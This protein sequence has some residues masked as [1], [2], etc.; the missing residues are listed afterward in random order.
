MRWTSTRT[1]K[2]DV[3]FLEAVLA[4]LPADGGLY[5]PA[6]LAPLDDVDALLAL[7][8]HA[9]S[10]A[11][12]G[13]LLAPEVDE[14]TLTALV[15][16]VFRF[17]APLVPIAPG[18]AALELFHGP[19]LSFK[20]FGAR[21]LAHVLGLAAARH[22]PGKDRLVLTATSG[23]TGSAVAHAFWQRPGFRVAVLYPR[24]RISPL[25]ERQ[26]ATLGGN[27]RAFAV[28]G[29]FDDCQALVKA[30]FADP[31]LSAQLGL[32]SANSINVARL[33]AQVLYYFEAVAQH[34]AR[35]GAASRPW[36]AVPSG[37]FGNLCAGLLAERLGL[38]VGGFV[39]ATNANRAVPDYLESG[40]Y[41]PRPSLATLSN[42]MDVGAPN[43]W[44]RIAWLFGN[45]WQRLRTAL[46]WGSR[47]DA[48]TLAE[49]ER[50]AALGYAADPHGAVASAV[51]RGSL[52]PEDEG[53]FL[54][55]AHPAKFEATAASVPLPPALAELGTKPLLT[56]ELEADEAALRRVLAQPA[57]SPSSS[58]S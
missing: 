38:P 11:I 24:G 49:L 54:A 47:A 25:Q 58:H 3:G 48:E 50:L 1:P 41:A 10:V 46:R 40:R 26:M 12:L 52:A 44:Q 23:D 14:R 37:N 56:E 57:P 18:L 33:V 7:P 31:E 39:A 8:W 32:T 55:T 28:A 21:F 45:D 17:P 30:C 5:V 16:E 22:A 19:T 34:R 35:R 6:D 51:L 27:V 20:D 13:H 2:L 43:N 9:R 42:A 36:I 15:P 53:I 29:S 4:N